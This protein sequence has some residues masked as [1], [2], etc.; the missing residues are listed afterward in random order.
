MTPTELRTLREAIGWTQ[1]QLAVYLRL[2]HRSQVCYLESGRAALYGPTLV[3]LEQL[4]DRYE[5]GEELQ[6]PRRLE[7]PPRLQDTPGH[8][9]E[10]RSGRTPPRKR[11][12][13]FNPF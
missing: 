3:L 8:K 10:P 12:P 9:P 4:K 5:R 2:R 11:V 6:P 13:S 7:T 1:D